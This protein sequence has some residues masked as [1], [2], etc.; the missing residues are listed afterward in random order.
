[1]SFGGRGPPDI[2]GLVSLKVDNISFN[3]GQEEIM[4]IFSEFGTVK[5]C[6][7]PKDRAT[8]NSRG[9]GFVRYE[10][11]G[12]P[13]PTPLPHVAREPPVRRP[14]RRRPMRRPRASTARTSAGA[15][16]VCP[17]R[18]CEPEAAARPAPALFSF[19]VPPLRMP[20]QHARPPIS[21]NPPPRRDE[22]P[23][24]DD[25]GRGGYDDRGRGGYDDRRND[26]RD[27]DRRR[28]RYDDHSIS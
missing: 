20:S 14:Q 15:L 4:E 23:R 13:T 12:L 27:D 17:L 3:T 9:F 28:D 6:Y 22:R 21:E 19:W 8:G 25:R 10:T 2:A 1:M 11:G 5:D 7:I 26:R 24:Y 16:S 18:R